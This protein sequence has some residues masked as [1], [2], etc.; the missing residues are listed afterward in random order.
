MK[1]ILSTLAAIF[2]GLFIALA[3]APVFAEKCTCD[4]SGKEGV[5]TSILGEPGRNERGDKVN[6]TCDDGSGSSVISVLNTVL[7]IMTVG[8]GIIGAIGIT[9]VGI[10]YMTAADNEEQTR[11]AKRRMFEI[12]I[13][14]AVYVL[15][16]ALLKWLLPGFGP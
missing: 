1:K 11:K 6:C 5:T 2:L 4:S 8:I 9:I 10:Q 16:Y 15:V 13:G 14:F 3:P 7:D 12:V